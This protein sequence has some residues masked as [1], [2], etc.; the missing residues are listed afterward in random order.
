LAVARVVSVE[1]MDMAWSPGLATTGA[2]MNSGLTGRR[3]VPTV[4]GSEHTGVDASPFHRV[5]SRR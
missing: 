2:Q 1:G 3:V 5:P 4:Q